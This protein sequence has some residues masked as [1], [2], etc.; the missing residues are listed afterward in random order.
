[1]TSPNQQCV[2][3]GKALVKKS[4]KYGVFLGCSGFPDCRYTKNL[5]DYYR[6]E[7]SKR[8]DK[9]AEVFREF[10]N[11]NISDNSWVNASSIGEVEFCAQSFYLRQTGVKP[12][13]RAVRRMKQG[14]IEHARVSSDRRCYIASYAFGEDHLVVES[15]SL[16]RDRVLLKTWYGKSFVFFYYKLSPILIHTLGRFRLFNKLSKTFVIKV[17]KWVG[18]I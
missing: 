1:M 7:R 10:G 2:K 8:L 11:Q 13:L 9:K 12:N 6:D 17:A 18:A 15:L 3:C 4:G 16:W 5:D 14:S